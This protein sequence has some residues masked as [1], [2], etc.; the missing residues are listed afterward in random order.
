MTQCEK[1]REPYGGFEQGPIRPPSESDSLLVRVTRN[2]PWNFCTFCPV[3][4][5]KRFSI[6]PVAHVLRDIDMVHKYVEM[7]REAA[8]GTD[9]ITRAMVQEAS[10]QVDPDEVDAFH[11]ALH[12][13]AGG[14]SS[15]FLQDANSLIIKP[16]DLVEILLHLRYRFP[17]I[18]RITSYARSHTIARITDP[19]LAAIREAGLNRIHIG[20]ESGS[21]RV[22][23]AVRKGTTQ[24]M[25]IQAGLKVRQA[26][27]EL[28][29]YVM[30][31][32]GGRALSREHA[33]ETADALNRIN[34]DFIRL[35][36]LAIPNHIPLYTEYREGRFEKCTDI[37][38][39][40]EILTFIRHLEGIT[41]TLKS[42]H[43][44]NLFQE[45][46]GVLPGDKDR[47]TAILQG[48]LDMHPER[49]TRYLVGRRLGIFRCLDDMASS[50]RMQKVEGICRKNG[51]TPANVDEMVDEMM[52]RF[53]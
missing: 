14:L 25:H 4:K 46:E 26:G 2:C 19:D 24:A 3:Y 8:G 30:P 13:F 31:G 49:Q 5:G 35:R 41:S 20:L 43:V 11:A 45:V 44:L 9:R 51:I 21:D 7:L 42:D 1:T 48:F 37:E 38:T 36:T 16:R 23:S 10:G 22:L 17:W 40:G 6:R 47:M 33:I 32:L 15:V 27:M 28:S 12:W 29:E 34:P 39:A 52:K 18:E 50:H 53:I